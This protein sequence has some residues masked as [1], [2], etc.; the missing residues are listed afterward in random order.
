[1]IIQSNIQKIYTYKNKNI[2]C[3]HSTHCYS[4]Q[5]RGTYRYFLYFIKNRLSPD[6]CRNRR[7]KNLSMR[8][9]GK[10]HRKVILG[11]RTLIKHIKNKIAM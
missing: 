6:I 8:K 11:S 10:C 5:K 9:I 4:E 2:I 1:M 7:Y 3:L